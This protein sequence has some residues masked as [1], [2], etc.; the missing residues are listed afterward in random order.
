VNPNDRT[1]PVNR[2]KFASTGG[3]EK[4]SPI[5]P[6]TVFA[7]RSNAGTNVSFEATADVGL[8]FE[9][10]RHRKADGQDDGK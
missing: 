1:S 10:Q 9:K 6:F 3:P 4:Q 5:L 8:F 2:T 7:N